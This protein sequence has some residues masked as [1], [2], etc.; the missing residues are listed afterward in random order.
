[1]GLLPITGR[2]GSLQTT[3]VQGKAP[4]GVTRAF[5]DGLGERFLLTDPESGDVLELLR[6]VPHFTTIAGFGPAVN[7]QAKFLSSFEH[8]AFSKIRRVEPMQSTQDNIVILSERIPGIRLAGLLRQ[9]QHSGQAIDVSVALGLARY[10]LAAVETLHVQGSDAVHGAIGPE[11]VMVTPQGRLVLLE[12]ILG[13]A[14]R[15]LELNRQELWNRFRIAAPSSAGLPRFDQRTDIAQVGLVAL[16]LVLG[17]AI[18][19]DEFPFKVGDL[20]A[21]ATEYIGASGR[22]PI[23]G[24]LRAWLTRALQ[25]DARW[26]FAT[27]AEAGRALDQLTSVHGYR[28]APRAIESFLARYQGQS[29]AGQPSAAAVTAAPKFATLSPPAQPAA[30]PAVDPK[31]ADVSRLPGLRRLFKLTGN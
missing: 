9:I 30:R 16:A 2:V 6:L 20:V 26:S 11:R 13:P 14:F 19:A 18:N 5:Q 21:S 25:L 28:T 15:T 4:S 7:R 24:K 27:A 10:L 17:R 29:V 22:Q 23:S 1:M 8:F 31:A 12:Y 3:P